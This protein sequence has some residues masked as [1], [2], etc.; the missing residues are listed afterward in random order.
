MRAGE[1]PRAVEFKHIPRIEAVSQ[2]LVE[3]FR[4]DARQFG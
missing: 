1:A 2:W 4:A 3:R